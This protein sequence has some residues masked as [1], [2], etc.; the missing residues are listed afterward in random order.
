MIELG[1]LSVKD[2]TARVEA[3]KKIRRLAEDLGYDPIHATRIEA[4]ASEIS[5]LASDGEEGINISLALDSMGGRSGLSMTFV[6]FCD[7]Y[8]S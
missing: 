6:L 3:L 4:I 1:E 5:R 8:P 2:P 7:Y